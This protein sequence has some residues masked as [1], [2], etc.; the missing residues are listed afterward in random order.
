MVHYFGF[1]H[2]VSLAT[3]TTKRAVSK[4]FQPFHRIHI[5]SDFKI[6]IVNDISANLIKLFLAVKTVELVLVVE[7]AGGYFH[8]VIKVLFNEIVEFVPALFHLKKFHDI[9]FHR[10]FG[11]IISKSV[12]FVGNKVISMIC[13]VFILVVKIK[14]IDTNQADIVVLVV[15]HGFNQQ[16]LN[17]VVISVEKRTVNLFFGAKRSEIAVLILLV[18]KSG[19]FNVFTT[20]FFNEHCE[21][22]TGDFFPVHSGISIEK[23]RSKTDAKTSEKIVESCNHIPRTKNGCHFFF[24]CNKHC[25]KIFPKLKINTSLDVFL[26]TAKRIEIIFF[27]LHKRFVFLLDIKDFSPK[28]FR[29]GKILF[30]LVNGL[31]VNSHFLIGGVAGTDFCKKFIRNFGFA[32]MV[33]GINRLLA[34]FTHFFKICV[35]IVFMRLKGKVNIMDFCLF[36]SKVFFRELR[37]S[38]NIFI[39]VVN[40]GGQKISS[41]ILNKFSPS[42]IMGIF[43]FIRNNRHTHTFTPW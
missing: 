4:R 17:R 16:T 35:H 26:F 42:L 24:I 18:K 31:I 23:S 15:F 30:S 19:K 32:I 12:L 37:D 10:S 27:P 7:C 13:T 2:I 3:T 39:P 20:S 9:R 36:R 38:G 25:S 41:D 14:P 34:Q 6:Q 8:K 22:L 21:K 28:F 5:V 43:S 40:H 1:I 29:F 11:N 33:I